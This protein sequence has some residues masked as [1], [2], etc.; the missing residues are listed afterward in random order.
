MQVQIDKKADLMLVVACWSAALTGLLLGIGL[1]LAATGS[2][3][4]LPAAVLAGAGFAGSLAHFFF[5]HAR[6]RVLQ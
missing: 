4:F 3:P 5:Q 1:T 6:Q 2:A